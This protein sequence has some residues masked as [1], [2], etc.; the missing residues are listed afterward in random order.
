M[1]AVLAELMK[2][3]RSLST[4]VVVLLPVVMVLTGSVMTLLEGQ[5]LDDGWHTLWMRSVVFY[6]MFPLPVGIAI[7]ASLVW[8]VEHRGTAWNALMSGPTRSWRIVLAKSAVITGMAAIMQVIAV[9]VCVLL[10]KLAFGLPGLL[11][12]EH[13]G[14]SALIV[15]ASMPVAVLQ[16][17][18]SMLLRSFAAPVAVAFV[19]AGFSTALLVADLEV[20]VLVSPYAALGR[21]TQLGTGAIADDGTITAGVLAM[22]VVGSVL[23][24]LVLTAVTTSVLER[25]DVRT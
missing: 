25:R 19:G 12:A 13:L 6:G 24:A 17:G 1:D 22:L 3:K 4:A 10:G 20:A 21:A 7:L 16:S 2:L 11:P 15:L 5:G 9:V 8:R 14:V 18:L 23:P